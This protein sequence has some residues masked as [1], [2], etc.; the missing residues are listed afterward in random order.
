MMV[1]VRIYFFQQTTQS[2]SYSYFVFGSCGQ[3][4]SCIVYNL[5]SA[6]S[7]PFSHIHLPSLVS[8][9]ASSFHDSFE[10]QLQ[11]YLQ[12]VWVMEPETT[13]QSG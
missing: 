4:W 11:I 12:S 6:A 9:V 1:R 7:P 3:K 5:I 8:F 13:D 2:H 10:D